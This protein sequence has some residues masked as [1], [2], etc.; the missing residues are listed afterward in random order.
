MILTW[1]WRVAMKVVC[2]VQGIEVMECSDVFTMGL[3]SAQENAVIIIELDAVCNILM[4][5][6]IL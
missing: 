5:L 1:T 3:F 4:L 2:S 6:F